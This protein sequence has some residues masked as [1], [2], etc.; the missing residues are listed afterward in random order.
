MAGNEIPYPPFPG[1]DNDSAAQSPSL[2]DDSP[3]LS[4]QVAAQPP[5]DALPPDLP[6]PQ[7]SPPQPP[8]KASPL[9]TI[10]SDIAMHRALLFALDTP[11]QLTPAVW[12]R[13][14][15]YIDN[16]W[17]SHQTTKPSPETGI[18][19]IYGSCRLSRKSNFPLPEITE[20]S[21]PRQRRETGICKAKFHLSIF[22]DGHRLVE[23]SGQSHS[24]TLEHI[25]SVK[26]NSAVR[27]L[28]LDDF[29]KSWEACGILAYL[30]DTSSSSHATDI[31]SDAGGRHIYRQEIQNVINGALKKAYPGQDI[32]VVK[33]Q[34]DK[35]KKYTTCPFKGCNAPGFPDKESLR[36]HRKAA[37]Q[38]KRHDHRDKIYICPI[39]ACYRSKKSKGLTTLLALEEHM[40]E[41]HGNAT[42][43]TE[44]FA[45]NSMTEQHIANQLSAASASPMTLA[46][47]MSGF[48][49]SMPGFEPD[50]ITPDSSDE[51]QQDDG[52]FSE[53]DMQAGAQ[54]AGDMFTQFEKDRMK[55]RIKRLES[56]KQKLD[57]EIRR[58]NTAVWG[59]ENGE[60]A[61][62][63]GGNDW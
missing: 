33:R 39:K 7:P 6:P 50:P 24:H 41:K 45:E 25:D 10:P 56:E 1:L 15:P 31:Y 47:N 13:F 19:K 27:N 4:P 60:H 46:L 49:G 5:E 57:Q 8:A 32:S 14:W 52:E 3:A 59:N 54:E 38:R 12:N 51:D 63:S 9:N 58:L 35:Y 55:V 36:A 62:T 48:M 37:H 22:P 20:N 11:V 26:R 2:E 28:V 16:V 30:R 34:M 43:V 40:R 21:R 18:V 17:C 53:D 23:R 61:M 44:I 29:F 42:P